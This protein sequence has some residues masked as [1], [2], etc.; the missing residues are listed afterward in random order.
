LKPLVDI[1]FN[2]ENI[3]IEPDMTIILRAEYE[4]CRNRIS[5]KTVDEQKLDD[6]VNTKDFYR[7]EDQF[8]NWLTYQR[9]NIINIDVNNITADNLA[10]KVIDIINTKKKA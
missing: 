4:I 8:Y 2:I 5:T 3:D 9:N 6:L 1:S 7:K 10:K